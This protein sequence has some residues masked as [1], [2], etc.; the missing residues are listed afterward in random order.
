M[1]VQFG[2]FELDTDRGRLLKHGIPVRIREQPLRVLVALIE[3]PGEIVAREDLRRR[4][5]SD[6][7]FVDFEVGLNSAISRTPRWT[8]CTSC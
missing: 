5:W 4:L 6:G 1:R 3:R 8:T 2:P 7:T